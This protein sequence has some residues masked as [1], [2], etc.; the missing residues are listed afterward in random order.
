M[1]RKGITLSAGSDAPI[2][3]LRPL[4]GIHAAVTRQDQA[5]EPQGGWV[6]GEKLSVAEALSLYT[7]GNVWHG[8]NEKRRGEI[9]PGRDAD[10]VVLDQDPFLIPASDIWKIGVAMTICGGRLTYRSDEI[11]Y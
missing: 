7:W 2:E 5:D 6:P 3:D 8:S 9:V 10:L 11:G 1:L 4:Y